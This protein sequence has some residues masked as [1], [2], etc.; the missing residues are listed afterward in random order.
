MALRTLPKVWDCMAPCSRLCYLHP[1]SSR[2]EFCFPSARSD[3]G[4]YPVLAKQALQWLWKEMCP[5]NQ[6]R[7]TRLLCL[8][9]KAC[10]RRTS[11]VPSQFKYNHLFWGFISSDQKLS[12]LPVLPSLE[13]VSSLFPFL[14][15]LC[16]HR[17]HHLILLSLSSSDHLNNNNSNNG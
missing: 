13:M 3:V 11:C 2:S 12:F 4:Y 17:G 10:A 15:L 5:I 7:N 8:E 6:F 1:C 9:E 16:H 14:G